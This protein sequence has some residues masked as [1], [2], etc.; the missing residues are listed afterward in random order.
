MHGRGRR[1]GK[2]R[3][4]GGGKARHV[5]RKQDTAGVSRQGMPRQ[6]R[7]GIAEQGRAGIADQGMA[8]HC[9]AGRVHGK[10]RQ[11]L[12]TILLYDTILACMTYD[13]NICC[14]II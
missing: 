12:H 3:E 11:G 13:V 7:A 1:Q 14:I 4:G 10:A 2:A 8:E 9:H 5:G 6:G